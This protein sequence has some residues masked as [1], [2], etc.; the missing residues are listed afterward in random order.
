MRPLRSGRFPHLHAHFDVAWLGFAAGLAVHNLELRRRVLRAPFR[1]GIDDDVRGRNNVD[2]YDRAALFVEADKLAG[3]RV[4][5]CHRFRDSFAVE[6]PCFGKANA[7][8]LG[9]K[10]LHAQFALEPTNC[11]GE[12]G[13]RYAKLLGAAR[14]MLAFRHFQKISQ[15][16][17]LHGVSLVFL[18]HNVKVMIDKQ[19]IY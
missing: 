13:L 12:R 10:K 5:F 17:K 14:D 6:A 19:F 1:D 9:L 7:A 15:L 18:N 2:A 4:N 11:L 16:Q 8:A 3:R